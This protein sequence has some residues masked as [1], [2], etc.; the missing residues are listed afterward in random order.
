M[1][2]VPIVYSIRVP[3]PVDIVA[4][5]IDVI[6]AVVVVVAVFERSNS[7]EGL[8]ECPNRGR[9]DRNSTALFFQM[10]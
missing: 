5:P 10:I 8:V 9:L 3:V 6:F 2:I 4:F 7:A 1:K